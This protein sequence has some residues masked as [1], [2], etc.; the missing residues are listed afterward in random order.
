[1][2]KL[3]TQFN[4][5]V[6]YEEPKSFVSVYEK[7][8]NNTLWL[9]LDNYNGTQEVNYKIK[10]YVIAEADGDITAI[11]YLNFG[12]K[13]KNAIA[14]YGTIADINRLTFTI[15]EGATLRGTATAVYS[16]TFDNDI[17]VELSLTGS[18]DELA[19]QM[20]SFNSVAVASGSGSTFYNQTLT[21]TDFQ[22]LRIRVQS[23]SLTHN[24]D[25]NVIE[26]K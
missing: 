15:F 7:L 20:R 12:A 2:A 16:K 1:M 23:Q 10:D 5:L 21:M 19:C 4:D 26:L 6:S 22:K 14:N 25:W 18:T 13:N 8:N 9:A 17:A 24:R 11:F 3:K